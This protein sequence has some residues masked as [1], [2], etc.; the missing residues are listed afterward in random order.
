[1]STVVLNQ[2]TSLN[3]HPLHPCRIHSSVWHDLGV[4]FQLH[5]PELKMVM[6][7]LPPDQGPWVAY[8]CQLVPQYPLHTNQ[9]HSQLPKV[10]LK[11]PQNNSV[12]QTI[13]GGLDLG[14]NSGLHTWKAGA[15]PH[16][17]HLQSVLLWLFWRWG[18]HKL[19]VQASL[20]C[21]PPDLSLPNRWYYR[22]EPLVLSSQTFLS[23]LQI[24][25]KI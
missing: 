24:L 4:I 5:F 12:S 7:V 16:K 20:N 13:L 6:F 19:F 21:N 17:P 9:K 15:L 11:P 18:T 8:Q 1:L 10:S 14:L 23:F 25:S 3:F 22:H 2:I